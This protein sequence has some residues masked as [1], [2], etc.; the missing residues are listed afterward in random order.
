MRKSAGMRYFV[1][2][3]SCTSG[4][5]V[6]SSC[7]IGKIATGNGRSAFATYAFAFEA[8]SRTSTP[9]KRTRSPYFAYAART[10]GKLSW[11]GSHH[12]ANRN[13]KAGFPPPSTGSGAPVDAVS[14]SGVAILPTSS[15][16]S[17]TVGAG[18]AAPSSASAPRSRSQGA[19]DMRR[20]RPA[21]SSPGVSFRTKRAKA[22]FRR[23]ASAA[24]TPP[25]APVVAPVRR[26]VRARRAGARRLFLARRRR[27]PR[28]GRRCRRA[29]GAAL[30][31][32]LQDGLAAEV[33]PPL[34]VD[35]DHLD[36]DLIAGLHDVLDALDALRR[37]L[38]D[39]HE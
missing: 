8:S 18:C 34:R 17:K 3:R 10:N 35:L 9:T 6:A 38:R 39:V 27:A 22:L 12:D 30:A 28:R 7:A 31:A 16:R 2:D 23:G 11:H 26:A 14:V 33:D 24:R 19:R 25:R 29:V 15:E 21:T 20:A 5:T 1:P 32:G 37:E 36:H 13:T 4:A